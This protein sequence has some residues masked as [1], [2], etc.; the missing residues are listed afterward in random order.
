MP[1]KD[2]AK[3]KA[4]KANIALIKVAIKKAASPDASGNP[5]WVGFAFSPGAKPEQ[6][7]FTMNARKKGPAVSKLLLKEIAKDSKGG[8]APKICF[9][10]ATVGK[11]GGKRVIWIEYIK[12][13]GGA[14]RRMNEALKFMHLPFIVKLREEDDTGAAP[15][16]PPQPGADEEED[17]TE[18]RADELEAADEEDDTG[19]FDEE[20]GEAEDEDAGTEEAEDED[21]D[22]EEDQEEDE[23]EEEEQAPAAAAA[24]P[25][26]QRTTT[27]YKDGAVVWSKTRQLMHANVAKFKA[28]VQQEYKDEPPELQSQI[29]TALGK[30]D[31][32]LNSFDDK[33]EQSLNKAHNAPDDTSRKTELANSKEI[34]KGYL[35]AMAS[36]PLVG[37]LDDNPFGV[38][39]N[40][41]LVLTKSLTQLARTVS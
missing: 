22:E 13:L 14:E 7:H 34:I 6:H 10:Q 5:R 3:E 33:L 40:I 4:R 1:E 15:P 18:D 24:Q 16:P 30:L 19:L 27:P 35:K 41:K 11:A 23:E 28:A 26:P 20:E 31:T 17:E 12:K 29:N 39:M 21:T 37:H 36:D 25:Q 38:D 32:M 2:P 8:P 9:G